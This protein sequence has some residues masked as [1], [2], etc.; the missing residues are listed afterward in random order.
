[1]EKDDRL[2]NFD[3]ATGTMLVAGQNTSERLRVTDFKDLAP[4]IGL[5]YA[6]GKG[7]K[8]VLR[9]GYGIGF[10]DPIGSASVLNSNEFNI[11]FYYRDNITEFP[12]TPPTYRL[13]SLLPSLTMP[14][15]L[16]PTGDQRYL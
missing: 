2:S 16:S 6:P 4:R 15:P 11:P 9:A 8:T 12:F 3:P 5:A 10:I 7:F 14:S 1:R 13:S